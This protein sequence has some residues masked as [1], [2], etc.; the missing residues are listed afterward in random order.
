MRRFQELTERGEVTDYET[1]LREQKERDFRDENRTV[2]PLR[3]RK[4]PFWWIRRGL[5]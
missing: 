1:V 4:M 5:A 2:S 3:R